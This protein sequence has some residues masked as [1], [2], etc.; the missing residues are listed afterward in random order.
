MGYEIEKKK[1]QDWHEDFGL[2]NLKNGITISLG[3]K[4]YRRA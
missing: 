1:S 2:R 3:Q 4:D